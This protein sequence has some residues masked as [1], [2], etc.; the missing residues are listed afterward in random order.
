[1][2]DYAELVVLNKFDKR[3]AE[4]L[5]DVR[6]LLMEA[7]QRCVP[8]R[9]RGCCRCIPPSPRSSTTPASGWM[10]A[11]L[12]RLM[13]REAVAAGGEMVAG[14]RHLIEGTRAARLRADPRQPRPLSRRNRRTGPRHQPP[15]RIAGRHRRSRAVVA[16]DMVLAIPRCRGAGAVSGECLP[17]CRA[18]KPDRRCMQTF[19]QIAARAAPTKRIRHC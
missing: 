11:N 15:H 10:F 2:L 9:R 14:H 16:V 18:D 1:M 3:G 8:D 7:Q 12:C 6:K 13:P 5:R 19:D 17:S 4:D